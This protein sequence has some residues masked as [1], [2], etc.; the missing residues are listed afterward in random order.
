MWIKDDEIVLFRQHAQY[1]DI[2]NQQD[3]DA[4]KYVYDSEGNLIHTKTTIT[5]EWEL[6]DINWYAG[7][8]IEKYYPLW[9]QS[10]ITREGGDTLSTMNT[11]INSVR[12][13]ANQSPVPN[14]WDG[15]LEAILP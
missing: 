13:W 12:E 2:K 10:N 11:F 9:K 3:L 6:S 15:T 8:H 14:P 7:Q 5:L 1:A 4:L